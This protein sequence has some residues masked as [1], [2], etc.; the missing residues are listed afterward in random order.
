MSSWLIAKSKQKRQ[1]KYAKLDV[2]LIFGQISRIPLT[3][4]ILDTVINEQ[5]V[6]LSSGLVSLSNC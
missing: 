2:L 6:G 1:E 5:I 4:C 3:F